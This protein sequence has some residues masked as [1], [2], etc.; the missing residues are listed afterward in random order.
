M[1]EYNMLS[2]SRSIIS[3]EIFF[4]Y[5]GLDIGRSIDLQE[6]ITH[7]FDQIMKAKICI[8]YIIMFR[9]IA[10]N[11]IYYRVLYTLLTQQ[12]PFQLQNMKKR[13]YG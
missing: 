9:Y 6:N 7:T 1:C 3:Y 13:R 2:R 11:F 10:M 8:M 12:Y 5:I 4:E